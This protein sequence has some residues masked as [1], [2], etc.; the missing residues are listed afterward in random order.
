MRRLIF[1]LV[2]FTLPVSAQHPTA[3]EFDAF[4]LRGMEQLGIPGVA[5]ALIEDGEIVHLASFG[6]TSVNGP[7]ITPQTPFQTGSVSKSFT[8]LLVAQLIDEGRVSLDDPVRMHIPWFRTRDTTASDQIT[9]HHLLSH[10]SGIA[11]LDGNRYQSTTYR[12]N[13]ALEQAVRRLRNARLHARPGETYQYSNANYAT[14]S[15]LI[16]IVEEQPFEEIAQARIFSKLGMSNSYI[17]VSDADTAAPAIGHTHWFGQTVERDFIPGRMMMGA[18]GTTA[19]A[20]DLATYLIAVMEADPRI[21]PPVL[22][23]ALSTSKEGAYEFGWSIDK[24]EGQPVIYHGGQ[25]AGFISMVE[26]DPE[27]KRGAL[28]LTNVSGS[29]EGAL[30]GG[31][32]DYAMGF[33]VRDIAPSKTIRLLFWS[34]VIIMVSLIV[35]CAFSIYRLFR[36]RVVRA[37]SAVKK[38]VGI[39]VPLLVLVVLAYV[40]AFVLPQ[41]NGANLMSARFFYPD[42]GLCLLVSSVTALFW[43]VTR[44]VLIVRLT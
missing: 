18:G 38:W 37:G 8:A 16:E 26:F 41:A 17:Q 10:R 9:L 5:G 1:L 7:P 14:L 28:V 4:L 29:M 30:A 12:G 36:R 6:V 22:A 2:F 31:A 13:D 24:I 33:S 21:A 40:L 42:I 32:V 35:A 25:N 27:S 34:A 23:K 3:E 44:T 19:S 15:L 43:A 39:V 20:E 11:T